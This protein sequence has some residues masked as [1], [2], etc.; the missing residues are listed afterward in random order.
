VV[1]VASAA[2][3]ECETYVLGTELRTGR[4]IDYVQGLT[5][6]HREAGYRI[7]A[8]DLRLSA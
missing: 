5:R 2:L 8:F 4:W 1:T 6:A 7:G 3:K